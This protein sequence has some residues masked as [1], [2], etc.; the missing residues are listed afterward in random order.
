MVDE[1]ERSHRRLAEGAGQV[2]PLPGRHPQPRALPGEERAA[3]WHASL[4]G[5]WAQHRWR[6][7]SPWLGAPDLTGWLEFSAHQRAE[8]RAIEMFGSNGYVWPWAQ[9]TFENWQSEFLQVFV[10]IVLTAFLVHRHSHE[11]P[12]TDY[13]TEASLRRIEARLDDIDARLGERP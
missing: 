8:G 7:C 6:S 1:C 13:E 11:S 12:D 3:R 10:F 5:L 9:A 2:V 4:A